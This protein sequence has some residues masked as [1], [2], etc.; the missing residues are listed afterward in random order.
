MFEVTARSRPAPALHEAEAMPASSGLENDRGVSVI[1]AIATALGLVLR[2]YQL[3]RPNY[4]SGVTGYDDGVDF[5]SAIRLVNGAVPYRDFVLVQP[6]GISLLMAPA[7]LLANAVGTDAALAVARIVTA[8]VGA[9]GVVLV[10]RLVRHRGPLATAL[11][12]G[13]LAVNPGAILASHSVLLEPWVVLFC[14]VGAL[15]VFD[16]DDVTTG[17]RRLALGAVAFGLAGA[18]KV[19]AILP[20]VVIL[21][22]CWWT[23][24]HR[25][26]LTYVAGVAV[27]FLVVVLPFVAFAPRAFYNDVIVAQLSRVEP[28]RVS[29][30]GRLTSLVGISDLS[31]ASSA[32]IV[33]SLAVAAFVLVCAVG[34]SLASRHRPP[35]LETFALGTAALIVLAFLWPP[36]YYPHYAGFFAPFLALAVALPAARLLGAITARSGRRRAVLTGVVGIAALALVAMAVAQFN[37]E[38]GLRTIDPAT[39]ADRQIPSGACVLTDMVSLTLVAD[40]FTSTDSRCPRLIDAIGTDYALAHGRSALAGASRDPTVQATWLAALRRAEFVWLYCGPPRAIHCNVSTNRRIPW[41]D[42]IRSYFLAHFRR[43][44]GPPP[45]LYG[46]RAANR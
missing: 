15:A 22:I 45:H 19:W 32:A 12:C 40:R 35:A 1:I 10:G 16:G 18:V 28:T 2:L 27:G 9:G 8:C 41:T 5:G 37:Y 24:G 13:I 31:T 46:R 25:A 17:D 11:A 6:P 7:G 23:R 20:V 14:L 3:A 30:A 36:D 39:A 4:L 29:L 38:A 44:P 43:L 42:R 34:A 21:V 33:A 26:A